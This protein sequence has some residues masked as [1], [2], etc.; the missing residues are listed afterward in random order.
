MVRRIESWERLRKYIHAKWGYVSSSCLWLVN[1]TL[2]IRQCSEFLLFTGTW[3]S[4][5]CY[6]HFIVGVFKDY[7]I[8][9]MFMFA[10]LLKLFFR[11]PLS[12]P[13]LFHFATPSWS[14][15]RVAHCWQQRV[16]QLISISGTNWE[17]K[18]N[19][20][21]QRSSVI[22]FEK[23][24]SEKAE[25]RCK[26]VLPV[27]LKLPLHGSDQCEIFCYVSFWVYHYFIKIELVKMSFSVPQSLKVLRTCDSLWV[28][29]GL[30]RLFAT[31]FFMPS[32]CN[33]ITHNTASMGIFYLC[34]NTAFSEKVGRWADQLV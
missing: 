33:K 9:C 10:P 5:Y 19:V 16:M 34:L 28:S 12:F 11:Q 17:M 29:S 13:S 24:C 14:S 25:Q 30:Q 32:Q 26:L 23:K 6:V 7:L 15:P 2:Y 22:L 8:L 4:I 18:S 3:F 1:S 31:L 20:S 27:N 21:L